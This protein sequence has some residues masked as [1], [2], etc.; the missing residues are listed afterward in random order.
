M[1]NFKLIWT[2]GVVLLLSSFAVFSQKSVDLKYH[3]SQGDQYSYAITM[4]QDITFETNG[5]TMTLNQ[6]IIFEQQSVVMAVTSDSIDIQSTLKRVK[7]VQSIFGMQVTYDSD[8]STTLQN[9][10]AAKIAET[11]GGMIGKSY[12]MIIDTRGNI[13]RTDLSNMVQNDDLSNNIS[14]G[15]Q[16][17]SYPDHKVKVGDSWEKE[18]SP[19]KTSDMK[20]KIKYTLLKVS[21]KQATLRIDGTITANTL[22]D[23]DMKLNG[24]QKGE[25]IVDIKTGW[26]IESKIDQ[27]I[28][29]NIEQNGMKI[30]ATISGTITAKSKKLN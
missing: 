15:T 5:Q 21:G 23:M 28:K 11:L 7:M 20:V 12:T 8:D 2:L 26:L 9:P 27:E 29:M 6:N 24:T 13:L 3:V 19:V 10:M 25:M 16:F 1:N 22:Q 30:P 14:S 18:L 4:D 17:G